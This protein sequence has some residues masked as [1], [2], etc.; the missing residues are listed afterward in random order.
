MYG[1]CH[2]Y[3]I[4]VLFYPSYKYLHLMKRKEKALP[5]TAEEV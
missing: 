3:V 5:Y 2:I 4:T 1:I